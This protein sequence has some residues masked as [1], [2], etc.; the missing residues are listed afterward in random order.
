MLSWLH[1]AIQLNSHVAL[2]GKVLLWDA[3]QATIGV[4][5]EVQGKGQQTVVRGRT[6]VSVGRWDVKSA[7]EQVLKEHKQV[8]QSTWIK[9]PPKCLGDLI[10]Q[11]QQYH[12][13][14]IVCIL[15]PVNEALRAVGARCSWSHRTGECLCLKVHLRGSVHVFFGISFSILP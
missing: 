12:T 13:A 9:E 4:E 1:L 11:E 7:V 8:L 15:Q 14:Q 6:A 2:A 3:L 5:P 10:N